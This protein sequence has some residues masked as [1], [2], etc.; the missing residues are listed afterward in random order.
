[1]GSAS[2]NYFK[3]LYFSV[4]GRIGRQAYWLF[5]ILPCFLTGIMLGFLIPALHI[6][7][8]MVLVLFFILLPV[9]VWVGIAVSVKRLHDIGLSGWWVM[10]CFIPFLHYVAVPVLGAIRGKVG[11]NVYG[12][13][14][15]RVRVP[16][17]GTAG[18][19]ESMRRRGALI[20]PN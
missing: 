20:P 2:T 5:M 9:L 14:P 17:A 4:R 3:W 16:T 12:E 13:D 1:M 11:A 19:S 10:L 15:H 18:A 8:R 7:I 6:P